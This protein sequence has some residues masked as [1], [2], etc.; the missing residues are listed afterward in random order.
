MKKAITTITPNGYLETMQRQNYFKS[1]V[2][3]IDAI[4]GTMK[5]VEPYH[6]ETPR[7]RLTE[8]DVRNFKD[9]PNGYRFRKSFEGYVVP[10]DKQGP[11]PATW[12]R[13]G[14]YINRNTAGIHDTI[15][16]GF[17]D[18]GNPTYELTYC[19][20]DDRCQLLKDD[21]YFEEKVKTLTGKERDDMLDEY[22]WK[23]IYTMSASSKDMT[24]KTATK[25]DAQ[26]DDGRLFDHVAIMG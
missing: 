9:F 5:D 3:K 23:A 17:G 13:Q 1:L 24:K 2:K 18:S 7:G 6:K 12:K 10:N 19:M 16:I 4:A 14:T 11:K 22:L 20:T 25:K 15:V 21:M 8:K 26:S